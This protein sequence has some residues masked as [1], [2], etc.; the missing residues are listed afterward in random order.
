MNNKHYKYLSEFV[1]GGMDGSITTF[2]VVAGAAGAN[3]SSSII[4]ILGIANLIADGFAMSV[5][6]FLSAKSQKQ[7]YEKL[8]QRE[9]WEIENQRKSEIEEIREIFTSKGFEGKLLEQIVD[10]ITQNEDVWVDIMMKHELEM[11]P[12]TRSSV[13]IGTATFTSFVLVGS[14]PLSIYVIDFI[15]PISY[16]LFLLSSIFTSIAFV[17]IGILKSHVTKT[18]RLRSITETLTLGGIAAMLAY[19]VGNLLQNIIQ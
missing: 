19:F 8:M 9:Y 7:Q 10:K 5:G 2:A 13:S 12:E 6:S 11:V 15:H 4:I 1:Y 3:L 16:N 17:V 14:I 18:H